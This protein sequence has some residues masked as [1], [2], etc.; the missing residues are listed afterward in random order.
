MFYNFQSGILRLIQEDSPWILIMMDVI[1]KDGFVIMDMNYLQEKM[2][3][4]ILQEIM[5]G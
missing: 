4:N 2:D 3:E 1:V 5:E